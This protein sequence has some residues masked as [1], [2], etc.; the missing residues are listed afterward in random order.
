M[1]L[2]TAGSLRR[3]ATSDRGGCGSEAYEDCHADRRSGTST[4]AGPMGATFVKA[5][6][7]YRQVTLDT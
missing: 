4:L 1:P 6:L 7:Q 2:D 5:S 3:G